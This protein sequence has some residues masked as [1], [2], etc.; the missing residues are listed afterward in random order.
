MAILG[1]IAR[2][3]LG[4]GLQSQTYN[5]CRMLKPQKIMLVNSVSFNGNEQHDYLY[6]GF[7]VQK[8]LGWPTNIECARFIKGLTHVITAETAYNQ[9]IYELAKLHGVR[10][11]TQPNWEFLDHLQ[12]RGLKG[13]YKWLM[14]SYWKLEEMK[15][16]FPNTVYLPPPIFINEFKK[17]RN[18][19]FERTHTRKFLHV[20]GKAAS[21]DRNG[22]LDLINAMKVSKGKFDLVIRSQFPLEEYQQ[23]TGNDSR[24]IFDINNYSD[25]SYVY[26][27]FDL[28][29]MPRRYGGLCL[30]MNEALCSGLPVIMTDISPNN[31][32]LPQKWLIESEAI[33]S[34]MGRSRIDIYK[35]D[36]LELALKLDWFANKDDDD[37]LNEK[38]EAFQIGHDNYSSDILKSKYMEIMEL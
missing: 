9:K 38:Y 32:V 27:D 28:M 10:V 36:I 34:F 14:P 2:S 6:E 21:H 12:N 11:F 16:L 8:T 4:S 1:E 35:T 17:A 29:V 19:N 22:T 25:Q 18:K 37:L 26:E 3:D 33:D 23:I 7:N 5:L 31:R 13:P 15:E 20:V 24:I 30:P